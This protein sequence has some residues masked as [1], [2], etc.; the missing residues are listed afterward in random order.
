MVWV[1]DLL[2]S[3]NRRKMA[4]DC[5]ILWNK[6]RSLDEKSVNKNIFSA[7][8]ICLFP[9]RLSLHMLWLHRMIA[10]VTVLKD[11]RLFLLQFFI[12]MLHFRFCALLKQHTVNS[13]T[14][15]ECIMKT[16]TYTAKAQHVSSSSFF[17][18]RYLIVVFV[19]LSTLAILQYIKKTHIFSCWRI[20]FHCDTNAFGVCICVL[21]TNKEYR[22]EKKE[23]SKKI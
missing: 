15:K 2:V 16:H 21:D 8:K 3:K 12:L 13:C 10:F 1:N 20:V 4:S 22:V 14:L 9:F 7:S 5:V 19:W 18:L 6:N 23:K 17:F 11:K